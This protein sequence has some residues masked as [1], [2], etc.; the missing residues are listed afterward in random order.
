MR[1]E[2]LGTPDGLL[3]FKGPRGNGSGIGRLY[4]RVTRL[5]EVGCV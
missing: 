5:Y 2:K 4:G 3:R 1:L